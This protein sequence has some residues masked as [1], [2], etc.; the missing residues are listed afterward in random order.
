MILTAGKSR[1]MQYM[2]KAVDDIADNLV[3][4]VG[5]NAAS[6]SD[7]VL[8]YQVLSLPIDE[9]SFRPTV[10]NTYDLIVKASVPTDYVGEIYEYGLSAAEINNLDLGVETRDMLS[11]SD[12][13]EDWDV[14]TFVDKRILGRGLRLSPTA[15]QTVT[16]SL[17]VVDLDFGAYNLATDVFKVALDSSGTIASAR[18]RFVTTGGNYDINLSPSGG[19]QIINV[20]MSSVLTSVTD[21]DDIINIEVSATA[22]GSSGTVTFD[23]LQSSIVLASRVPETLYVRGV[24]SGGFKIT[25]VGNSVVEIHIPVVIT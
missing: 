5:S 16:S 19:Y 13:E 11:F 18:I 17:D 9:L 14:G 23:G 8:A 21:L 6:A 1:I 15:A 25:P 7:A 4:G 3:L 22:G 24:I 2:S 10:T 12:A 20:P